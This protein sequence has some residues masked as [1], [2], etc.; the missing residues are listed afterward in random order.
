[1]P[2]RPGSLSFTL[3]LGVLIAL[4][5]FT[6]D[7]YM[8]AMPVLVASLNTDVPGVQ[9]TLAAFIAGI[10]I[11]QIVY[12]PLSD[13][14]GRRPMLIAGLA[15]FAAS[16]AACA[17][18]HTVDALAALRF[19]QALGLTGCRGLDPRHRS[20]APIARYEGSRAGNRAGR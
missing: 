16:S 20:T 19:L 18:S 12:G 9:F 13:R 8:P 7:I 14:Y 4:M 11:G 6:N 17:F 1:M 3:V 15:V 2:L 10:A 5:P